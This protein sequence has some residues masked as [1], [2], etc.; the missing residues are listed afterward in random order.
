MIFLEN[1]HTTLKMRTKLKCFAP[2]IR[3]KNLTQK[4]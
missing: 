1:N 4:S 2:P 3:I